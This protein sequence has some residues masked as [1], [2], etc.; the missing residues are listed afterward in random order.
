MAAATD[1]LE[2]LLLNHLFINTTVTNVG[3]AT[4]LPAAAT[5]GSTQLSLATVAYIDAD[6]LMT[7]DEC[8][9]TGYVRPLQARTTGG[10]DT[11]AAGANANAAIITFGASSS[12]PET[13]VHCGLSFIATGD[14]LHL[15]ADLGA[16][17][18]IN[19]GVEPQFAAGALTWTLA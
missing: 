18:V 2:I 3:D 13:A 1:A 10:W 14:V 9:Y 6:T 16:D 15:H 4:G 11:A 17:L 12:G 19:S 8:A 7:A 5:V